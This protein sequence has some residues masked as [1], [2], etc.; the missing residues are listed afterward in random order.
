S[1]ASILLS[2]WLASTVLHSLDAHALGLHFGP[3]DTIFFGGGVL[4]TLVGVWAIGAMRGIGPPPAPTEPAS[5]ED[6]PAVAIPVQP[7][8]DVIDRMEPVET[9]PREG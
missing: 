9:P 1:A 3:I 5:A 4:I 6:V 8:V 7:T 2:T